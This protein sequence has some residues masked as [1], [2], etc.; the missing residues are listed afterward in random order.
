MA[1]WTHA[2]LDDWLATYKGPMFGRWR[3]VGS[4]WW[5][6]DNY[7]SSASFPGATTV[8]VQ[9]VFYSDVAL[10]AQAADPPTAAFN[11][12][13]QLQEQEIEGDGW[14]TPSTQFWYTVAVTVTP[15]GTTKFIPTPYGTP[16]SIRT[17]GLPI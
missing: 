7:V 5:F 13:D 10:T 1:D 3:L 14:C 4:Y 2:E 6:T 12:S 9:T 16:F 8:S 15:P 17:P 11:A